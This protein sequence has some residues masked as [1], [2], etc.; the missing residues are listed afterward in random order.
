MFETELKN[1]LNILE[2]V[3]GTKKLKNLKKSVKF[4]DINKQRYD[5][6]QEG[7]DQFQIKLVL[8]L[9][10]IQSLFICYLLFILVNY[11]SNFFFTNF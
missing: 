4:M 5:P 11:F 9:F 2:Q 8:C 1:N 6:G 3:V 10:L 7:H